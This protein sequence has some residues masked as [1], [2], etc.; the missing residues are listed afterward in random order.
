MFSFDGEVSAIFPDMAKRAIPNFY[1]AHASHA[2]MLNRWVKPG[3]T[4]MDVGASRGAFFQALKDAYPDEWARGDFKLFAIDTSPDMCS[5]LEEEFPSVKTS[6][7]DISSDSPLTSFEQYDVVC[8]HYVLQFVQEDKQEAVVRKLMDMVKPGG[9]FI[10]GHKARHYGT[11]GKYMHDEYM[12]FRQRNGYTPEEIAAKTQA[13][14]GSMFPVDHD[15]LMQ[16]LRLRFSEV[17]ETYRFMMF[18]TIFAR[19]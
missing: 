19:K 4:V 16:G 10:Y 5:Y 17:V 1:E 6:C 7:S 13:L 18:S 15:R 2:R 12:L 9:V 11:L 8:A 3:M 14:Q